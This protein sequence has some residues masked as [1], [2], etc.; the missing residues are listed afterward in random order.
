MNNQLTRLAVLAVTLIA[1]AAMASD[2]PHCVTGKNSFGTT[3]TQ[4]D[5]G[6]TTI[7]SLDK[8]IVCHAGNTPEPECR[9]IKL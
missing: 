6:T 7:T 3:T 5:D 9:E 1:P 8:V 2:S 4:C